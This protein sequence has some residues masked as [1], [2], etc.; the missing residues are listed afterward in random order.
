MALDHPVQA[1]YRLEGPVGPVGHGIHKEHA[2]PGK[3]IRARR[4]RSCFKG[5]GLVRQEVLD[6]GG[7]ALVTGQE[8]GLNLEALY[9]LRALVPESLPRPEGEGE[10]P[11]PLGDFAAVAGLTLEKEVQ[12]EALHSFAG[13]PEIAPQ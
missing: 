13:G 11:G 5:T 4:L 2:A 9:T 7:Q 3:G 10:A 8:E 6:P 1:Q 12:D